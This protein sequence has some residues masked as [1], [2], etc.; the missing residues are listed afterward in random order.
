VY[1]LLGSKNTPEKQNKQKKMCH[2]TKNE[3]DSERYFTDIIMCF[4]CL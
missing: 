3:G 4:V 1:I 2:Q